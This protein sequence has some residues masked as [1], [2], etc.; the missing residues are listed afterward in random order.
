M[1]QAH[2]VRPVKPKLEVLQGY[3]AMRS[4]S[5]SKIK[6]GGITMSKSRISKIKSEVLQNHKV[7]AVKSKLEVEDLCIAELEE[8]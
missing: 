5:R 3:K 2:K 8:V 1:Y 4:Q 6:T 7:V